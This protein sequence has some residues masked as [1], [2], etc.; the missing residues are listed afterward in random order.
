MNKILFLIALIGLLVAAAGCE[1]QR[2]LYPKFAIDQQVSIV[3][4]FYRGH[5]GVVDSWETCRD[6]DTQEA[7]V[8]YHIYVTQGSEPDI[9]RSMYFPVNEKDLK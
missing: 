9:H 5:I 8:C 4:G 3:S 7:T 6:R 1:K 2:I